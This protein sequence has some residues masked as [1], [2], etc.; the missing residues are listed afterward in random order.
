MASSFTTHLGI[1]EMTTGEKSGTWGTITNYNWDI[2]DRIASYKAVAITTNADT[3]TLTVR[4]ASPGTGTENLQDGMYRVVKFTGALDSNCT[5]TIAPNTTQVF[6]IIINATTDSGSSGPYSVILSQGS[7]A[8]ITVENGKSAVVYCDGAGGGAAVIDALSNLQL[9]TV[10]SSGDITASGTFN[11]LGD[12]AADDKAAMGYTSAEGLILTGQGSTNDVTIKNDAD[13]DVLE[14]P[15]GGTNVTVVGDITAGGTVGATG[16]TAAGDDA[17]LGYTSAEGL[18]L[19]GQGSTNDVTIKNDADADV[20]TI[21]TG[22]TNVDIVGDVTAS[23]VN[24]DGDTSAG[25]DAA[26]GY[27]SAE[28]LILTGQGSTND[29]TIKNDADADVITIATGGTNVD[30]VGDVTAATVNADG[31][32]SAGDNA[33]M[34]YTAAEGLILTGQGSTNDVTIKNDADADVLEIPTG[35]TNVSVVGSVTASSF[36]GSGSGL[37]AG[38][39]PIT[40]LDI[41]GGTDIGEAIVDADL[42]IVDNGAGGTNRKVEASRLKTYAGGAG[43]VK[44]ATG[45]FSGSETNVTLSGIDTTYDTYLCTVSD[46]RPGNDDVNLRMYLGT[47]GGFL[48][49]DEYNSFMT[50]VYNGLTGTT[51]NTYSAYTGD[52]KQEFN[53]AGIGNDADYGI[54]GV[55]WLHFPG[56]PTVRN[57]YTWECS[58]MSFNNYFYGVRGQGGLDEDYDITQVKFQWSGGN[59]ASGR[60]TL[61]GLSHA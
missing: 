22:G 11:A 38:T 2:M 28:G 18:I 14:I 17:A 52:S 1:E 46:C 54:G 20:I 21:A 16:D 12:T 32:T 51:Y 53:L 42:F 26:M 43:L 40:T 23:T 19:T 39:T 13:A 55:M 27:T 15:T 3:A 35:T 41:D 57:L 10:T 29:V 4:E 56:D 7:G 9:A 61:Y 5:V 60:C 8:N 45:T 25:D 33:A 31:D 36:A 48:T 50:N 44:I 24:A 34:G 37:T 49:T 6:F 47:S 30:I 59:G 58:Y